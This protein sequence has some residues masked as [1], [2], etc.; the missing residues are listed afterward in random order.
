MAEKTLVKKQD[1][2]IELPQD[3]KGTWGA[4]K[5][6]DTSDIKIPRLLLMQGQSQL[7]QHEKAMQGAIVRST[8]D[9]V[10]ADKGK[11]V[12]FIPLMYF[13]TWMIFKRVGLKFEYQAFEPF[14]VDNKDLPL[15]WIDGNTEYRRDKVLNFYVLLPN[16][17]EKELVALKKAAAGEIPDTDMC[18]LPCLISFR[19][20]SYSAGKDITSHF[21]KADHFGVSPATKVFALGSELQKNENNAYHVYRVD[22]SRLTTLEELKVCKTWYDTIS[23]V[24]VVVDAPE[25][26]EDPKYVQHP[27]MEF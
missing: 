14:N 13:K 2:A 8:T 16:D 20:T 26:M 22:K 23:K 5:G 15:T 7:V 6:I 11:S 4:T 1:T 19:R 18:L 17:I 9:E 12:E 24:N 21:A 27:A 3:L 25:E 10:L